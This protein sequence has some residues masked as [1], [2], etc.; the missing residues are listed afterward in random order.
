MEGKE[1]GKGP[2][3]GGRK[4]DSWEKGAA[5]AGR[6]CGEREGHLRQSTIWKQHQTE[7]RAP[8]TK[9]QIIIAPTGK[10]PFSILHPFPLSSVSCDAFHFD[11]SN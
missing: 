1:K 5:I 4:A 7:N 10:F 11:L 9:A 8:K 2:Q 6:T 3:R